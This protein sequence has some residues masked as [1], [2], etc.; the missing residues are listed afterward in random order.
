METSIREENIKIEGIDFNAPAAVFSGK[1]TYNAHE[2][3]D[4]HNGHEVFSLETAKEDFLRACRAIELYPAN[5]CVYGRDEDAP[6]LS[7][8]G[9]ILAL[10]FRGHESVEAA[11][12]AHSMTLYGQFRKQGRQRPARPAWALEETQAKPAW[13][14]WNHM[15]GDIADCIVKRALAYASMDGDVWIPVIYEKE[16]GRED[17]LE[18]ANVVLHDWDLDFIYDCQ[19]YSNWRGIDVFEKDLVTPFGYGKA[20]GATAIVRAKLAAY[21]TLPIFY[22]PG[23]NLRALKE[24]AVSEYVRIAPDGMKHIR[25][26]VYL[27]YELSPKPVGCP[28]FLAYKAA[29]GCDPKSSLYVVRGNIVYVINEY[30]LQRALETGIIKLSDYGKGVHIDVFHER[31]RLDGYS[32]D[33]RADDI[34]RL[35]MRAVKE[36]QEMEMNLDVLQKWFLFLHENLD[37]EDYV[38]P[39]KEREVVI[40]GDLGGKEAAKKWLEEF[41]DEL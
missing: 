41:A 9:S 4:S 13:S 2:H 3:F 21:I 24:R 28:R 19:W 12:R 11:A 7:V 40:R 22:R 20:Y 14:P 27:F 15:P 37:M 18:K 30:T 10:P 31:I 35:I 17:L 16:D 8:K 29:E 33:M 25:P 26:N 23:E 1:V 36:F 39:L 32:D 38:L 5:D 6:L 34:A